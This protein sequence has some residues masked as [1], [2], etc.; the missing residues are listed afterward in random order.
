MKIPK[1]IKIGAIT[2]DI[3]IEPLDEAYGEFDRYTST[4]RIDSQLPKQ[5]QEAALFH[6]IFHVMNVCFDDGDRGIFHALMESLSLQ[7]YQ[8]LS[9]NALLK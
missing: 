2:Y 7:L 5:E 9:D 6:E 1:Q 8:V 4:I 3:V